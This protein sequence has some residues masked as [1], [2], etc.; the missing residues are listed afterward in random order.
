[1]PDRF[2]EICAREQ[3]EEAEQRARE[4]ALLQT[5]KIQVERVIIHT[6][7]EVS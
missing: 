3:A 1:M 6:W 2:T 4:Q 7:T 5:Q